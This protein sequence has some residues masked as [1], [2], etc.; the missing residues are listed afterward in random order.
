MHHLPLGPGTL[1][2]KGEEG[3]ELEGKR[4]QEGI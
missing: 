4:A 1:Q 2:P 3:R